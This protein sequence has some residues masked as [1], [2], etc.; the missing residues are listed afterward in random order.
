MDKLTDI[1]MV[2]FNRLDLTKKTLESL[3]KT[4]KS[5]F[6]LIIVDN[7]SSDGGYLDYLFDFCTTNAKSEHFQD[8]RIISNETNLGIAI[9]RN[10][11]LEVSSSQ[12]LSTIDNDVILP[13]LWLS[14]CIDIL[15]NNKSYGMIGVNFEKNNYPLVTVGGRCWQNKARGNLGTACTVFNRS[16][17][18]QLGY[19]NTE[20][21]KYGE[22]DADFGVRVKVAGFKLG[23]LKNNGT[24]L[25][26]G[27]NDVGE[28]REYK[29]VS[30]RNNLNKFYK[31]CNDYLSR[32][33]PIYID[34]K[35]NK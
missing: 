12:W 23:Y 1:M 25:G 7:G 28:Y 34:Y 10:Q 33:K 5:P 11:A 21:G 16:L 35:G 17:H 29:H 6:N 19:F 9:G 15:E 32:R 26:E 24:H 4:T 20:Y 18:D 8:F 3:V 27:D 2:T 31:N 22:E 13:E 30:H 14:D